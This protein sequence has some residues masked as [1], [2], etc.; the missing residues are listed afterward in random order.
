MQKRFGGMIV[1][2]RL[3]T[4]DCLHSVFE[5]AVGGEDMDTAQILMLRDCISNFWLSGV[6]WRGA[7]D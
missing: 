6:K 3:N 2:A 4:N 1:G 5:Q 7:V